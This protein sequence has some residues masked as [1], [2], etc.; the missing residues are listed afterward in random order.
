MSVIKGIIVP[1]YNITDLHDK[2][3]EAIVARKLVTRGTMISIV[4]SSYPLLIEVL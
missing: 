1:M 4:L 2:V 3:Q